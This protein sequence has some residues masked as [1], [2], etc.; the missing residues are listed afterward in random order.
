MRSPGRC[1]QLSVAARFATLP[2]LFGRQ[3]SPSF[4]PL[5][6][7]TRERKMK[8]E[9]KRKQKKTPEQC[10]LPKPDQGLLANTKSIHYR[11]YRVK[12][13]DKRCLLG[14]RQY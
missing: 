6:V 3:D 7:A 4:A 1:W 13:S 9:K 5:P 11:D 14:T 8:K 12:S 10:W 2:T